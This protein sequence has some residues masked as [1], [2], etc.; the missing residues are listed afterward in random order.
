M[1]AQRK[2][3]IST[4]L[5]MM[6]MLVSGAALLLACAG[7]FAYDQITFRESLVRTLSAQGQI[8][9]SNSASALL[10]DDPQAALNTLSA[11]KSFPNIV[12]AGILTAT[13]QTFAQYSRDCQD[14]LLN[15]PVLR[16]DQ[17][18][19][20]RFG[21]THLI[22]VRKIVLDQKLIGFVYLRA[23]LNHVL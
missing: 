11:L 2:Q 20:Y 16:D 12:S 10:F 5:T 19:A 22:L 3:S 7:F 13:R 6:N 15:V 1:I 4:K 23:D 18:E 9:G 8:I 14:E 21:S 17:A